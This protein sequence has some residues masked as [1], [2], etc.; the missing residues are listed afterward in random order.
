MNIVVKIPIVAVVEVVLY[1]HNLAIGVVVGVLVNALW[2]KI[3]RDCVNFAIKKDG[4]KVWLQ[5]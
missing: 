5:M 4:L 3:K 1:T 2:I